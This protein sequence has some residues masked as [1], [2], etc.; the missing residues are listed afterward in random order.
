[1]SRPPNPHGGTLCGERTQAV[2]RDPER[3]N[4]NGDGW[5]L[6]IVVRYLATALVALE[7]D[8]TGLL[9]GLLE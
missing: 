6:G 7:D 4:Q 5:A 1:L 8:E 3:A 9:G 2:D